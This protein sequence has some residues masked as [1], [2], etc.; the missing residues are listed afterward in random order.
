MDLSLPI[1]DGWEATRR[2]KEDPSTKDIRVVILS[3]HA[4]DGHSRSA[5][6][7]GCDAF[8]TKPCLPRDLLDE[9]QSLLG[10]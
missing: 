6:E 5:K 8:L 1:M 4:L 2:L 9:L 3:G 7:A 10:G